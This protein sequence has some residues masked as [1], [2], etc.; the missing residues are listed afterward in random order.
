MILA[1]F[2]LTIGSAVLLVMGLR[3]DP[4]DTTFIWASVGTSVAAA[5]CIALA[6]V[7]RRGEAVVDGP[8]S[9]TSPPPWPPKAGAVPEPS[10][11]RPPDDEGV[12]ASVEPSAAELVE[13]GEQP[14]E[15]PA[16]EFVPPGDAAL[17]DQIQAD[18]ALTV[19]V[20][21]GRPRYHLASCSA[22]ERGEPVTISLARAREAGFTPCARCHSAGVLAATA[23]RGGPDT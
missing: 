3:P 23:R 10:W 1:S 5:V 6:V 21:D 2:A 17:L 15:E 11:S 19:R 12:A 7:R 22:L 14:D 9:D 4:V 13:P 20:L 16:E 8:D 18:P